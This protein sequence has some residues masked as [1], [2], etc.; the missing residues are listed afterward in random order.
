M[1]KNIIIAV[2]VVALLGLGFVK[3]TPLLG[4]TGQTHYQVESFLRGMTF[5]TTRQS[6]LGSDG[7][8][9]LNGG[10]PVKEV[11][12]GTASWNPAALGPLTTSTSTATTS[13]TITGAAVGDNCIVGLTS[14]TGTGAFAL[15][16]G[17]TS[18]NTAIVSLRNG[19][20]SVLDLATGTLRASVV[21]F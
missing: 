1:T 13:V 21:Q 11:I 12:S 16:C 2:L 3:I 6:T 8:L 9:T 10:T 5:G 17:I 7:Y 15:S 4:A 14:A 18:S 20:A 19:D